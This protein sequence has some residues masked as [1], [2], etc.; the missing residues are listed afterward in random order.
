MIQRGYEDIGRITMQHPRV[1]LTAGTLLSAFFG[2]AAAQCPSNMVGYWPMNG[3]AREVVGDTQS[4]LVGNVTFA[5]GVVASG[6]EFD[7]F[8]AYVQATPRAEL[9]LGGASNMSVAAWARREPDA[10]FGDSAGAII[11]SRTLCNLGNWQLY[12]HIFNAAYYSKWQSDGDEDQF[13]TSHTMPTSTWEHLVFTYQ[14]GEIRFY[15]NGTLSETLAPLTFGGPINTASNDIQLGWDSCDS[16][17]TG[18][19]DEVAVFDT[20][21]SATEVAD[22]YQKGVDGEALCEEAA[23]AVPL[24]AGAGTNDQF[25]KA[26]ATDG[27]LFV[28]GQPEANGGEGQVVVYRQEG[29]DLIEEAVLPVPADHAAAGF[30]A[31]LAL[32]GGRLVIGAPKE[33]AAAA[34]GLVALK[35]AIYERLNNGTWSMKATLAPVNGNA[36]DEFGAAV[37]LDGNRIVVGAPG[38]SEGEPAGSGA[39]YAYDFANDTVS[40]ARKL[41]P[42]DQPEG[43]KFG[44]SVATAGG[45]IAVGAPGTVA[46]GAATG[47]VRL[48]KQISDN[49]ADL[50]DRGSITGSTGDG[51]GFGTAVAMTAAT[52]IVGAPGE[53]GSGADQGALY[54]LDPENTTSTNKLTPDT[55]QD[56]AGFGLAV[57]VNATA[58]VVGAPGFDAGAGAAYRFELASLAQKQITPKIADLKGFGSSVSISTNGLVIGAPNTAGDTGSAVAQ[59]DIVL[60][61]RS[62]FE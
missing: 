37:A 20:T 50:D 42:A 24:P 28:I 35:A 13:V 41:K 16:Y 29:Q 48:F 27:N 36:G 53:D 1:L 31:A 43:S 57:A 55:P 6:A 9:N 22:I 30:G 51:D 62:G 10:A 61:Y 54:L 7:G 44:S 26:V 2:D 17:W 23:V 14:D 40:Q 45:M 4:S 58:G 15:L 52:I 5:P 47:A 56:N 34:K 8:G 32:E 49:L 60:I 12:G 19:I 33:P 21:L 59:T 3:N 39:A 25:G 38:D 46:G 18:G 11:S